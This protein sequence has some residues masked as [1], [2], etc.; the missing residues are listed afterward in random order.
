MYRR[1]YE[2]HRDERIA[3][4]QRWRAENPERAREGNIR[5]QRVTRWHVSITHR[6]MS[7]A[8]RRGH[9]F[10]LDADFVLALFE[11]QGRRCYWLG[12]EMVPSVGTR[13]PLQ[14]SID[15]LDPSRGYTRDN[16]VI[17]SQFANMGRSTMSAERF[18]VFLRE[19]RESWLSD[20]AT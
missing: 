7:N 11:E 17:A 19:L 4:A 14:P 12:V 1:F 20:Q 6:C 8:K 13:E 3:D 10:D 16:V 5:C 2:N 9:D 18:R 15:R